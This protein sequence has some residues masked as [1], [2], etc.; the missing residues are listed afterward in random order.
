MHRDDPASQP[1][2]DDLQRVHDAPHRGVEFDPAGRRPVLVHLDVRQRHQRIDQPRHARRLFFHD[3]QKALLGCGIVRRRSAQG[4]QKPGQ[5]G[6]RRAQFVGDVGNQIDPH[7]V[8]PDLGG[9]VAQENQRALPA[10][11]PFVGAFR[12]VGR[13]GR[14]RR[15]ERCDQGLEMAVLRHR[16]ADRHLPP[17]TVLDGLLNRRQQ[18]RVPDRIR[19]RPSLGHAAQQIL[20]RPADG[21]N[22]AALVDQDGG[23]RQVPHQTDRRLPDGSAGILVAGVFRSGRCEARGLGPVTPQ[24]PRPDGPEGQ[25]RGDAGYDAGQY[26]LQGAGAGVDNAGYGPGGGPDGQ[27]R[28]EVAPGFL[29]RGGGSGHAAARP[30]GHPLRGFPIRFRS[31]GARVDHRRPSVADPGRCPE[32][33]RHGLF[34]RALYAPDMTSRRTARGNGTRVSAVSSFGFS[35]RPESIPCPSFLRSVPDSIRGSG[36]IDGEGTGFVRRRKPNRDTTG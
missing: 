21:R 14:Q 25:R 17:D 28:C 24:R 33:S 12:P 9:Q 32:R 22:L 23:R 3:P 8:G 26:A 1:V 15:I 13:I 20:G 16:F 34:H 18:F 36:R 7:P 31:I 11:L 29:R 30:F 10:G 2:G 35:R 6:E 19:Q 27:G 5:R 4:F